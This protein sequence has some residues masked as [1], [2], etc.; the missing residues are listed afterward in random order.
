MHGVSPP[1]CSVLSEQLQITFVLLG[2]RALAWGQRDLHSNP[3]QYS[4]L[5]NPMNRGTW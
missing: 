4:C 2:R 3:L 5:V 1:Y